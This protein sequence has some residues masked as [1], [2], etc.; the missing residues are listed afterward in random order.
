VNQ[1]LVIELSCSAEIHLR[2]LD[3]FCFVI[4]LLKSDS[5]TLYNHGI[6]H[7]VYEVIE[8]EQWGGKIR[9]EETLH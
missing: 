1:I 5:V 6:S 8:E 4:Q 9:G 2:G 3:Y 7:L